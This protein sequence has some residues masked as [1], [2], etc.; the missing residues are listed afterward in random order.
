MSLLTKWLLNFTGNQRYSWFQSCSDG[1]SKGVY[2]YTSGFAVF[3][4]FFLLKENWGLVIYYF[5]AIDGFEVRCALPWCKDKVVRNSFKAFNASWRNKRDGRKAE[6]EETK[7]IKWYECLNQVLVTDLKKLKASMF[8]ELCKSTVL[9]RY[10]IGRR[11][12]VT[13]IRLQKIDLNPDLITFRVDHLICISVWQWGKE[14]KHG[15]MCNNLN[16]WIWSFA[17]LM[18]SSPIDLCI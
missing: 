9:A 2:I 10:N 11:T 8:P 6:E 13:R 15:H 7:E 3:V 5:I 14:E 16:W 1:S 4:V 12:L 17:C 18:D